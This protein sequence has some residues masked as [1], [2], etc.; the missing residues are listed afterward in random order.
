MEQDICAHNKILRTAVKSMDW[1]QLL[2]NCHPL[3]REGYARRLNQGGFIHRSQA[4]EYCRGR[5]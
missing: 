2:N 1:I 4:A 5:L 3:Y